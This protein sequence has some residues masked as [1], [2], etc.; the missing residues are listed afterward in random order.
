MNWRGAAEGIRNL[1]Y[2]RET[3]QKSKSAGGATF[4]NLEVTIYAHEMV[5][6]YLLGM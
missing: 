2:V 3:L 5:E 1:Y 4:P 6:L